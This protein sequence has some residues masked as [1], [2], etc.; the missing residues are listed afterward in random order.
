MFF[1]NISLSDICKQIKMIVFFKTNHQE[2]IL[3]TKIPFQSVLQV[4]FGKCS[5]VLSLFG[6]E[7]TSPF[8]MKRIKF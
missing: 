7:M 6:Q 1:A 3:I 8:S 5:L 2:A 4:K